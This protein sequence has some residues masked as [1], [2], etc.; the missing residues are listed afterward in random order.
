MKPRRI[1]SVVLSGMLIAMQLLMPISQAY[2]AGTS[3]VSPAPVDPQVLGP[4][5]AENADGTPAP[6]PGRRVQIEQPAYIP[7]A[8]TSLSAP[9]A[10]AETP[11]GVGNNN[12]GQQQR[13]TDNP[14]NHPG[15]HFAG[16][17]NLLN[18]NFFL[19]VG[20]F[21]IPGRGL[22]LQLARSYNSLAAANGE[23]GAF[24]YGWTHS[25]ETHI[26]DA[27]GGL[28]L[29]VVEA[30]GARH[31]YGNRHPCDPSDPLGDICYDSPPG[32][33][34]ELRDMVGGNYLLTHKNGTL[35]VFNDAGQL[36][37]IIDRYGNEINL[38]YYPDTHC[39]PDF[40]GP[41][42]TLCRV[43]DPS[44]RRSLLFHAPG[45][46]IELVQEWFHPG[47][48]G[49]AINYLYVDD[50]LVDVAY[51]EEP[52]SAPHN[53][54][55][56]EFNRMIAYN[57]PRQ[58][59]G[60]RQ[61]QA[62]VYDVQHRVERVTYFVD[63]FFDVFFEVDYAPPPRGDNG[64]LSEP[65]QA[66]V[67]AVE[68]VDGAGQLSR[69]EYGANS[70]I[71]YEGDYFYEY[72]HGWWWGKWWWWHPYPRWYLLAS[73]VDANLHETSYDYDPWGNTALIVNAAGAEQQFLWEP[74]A[75]EAP[76]AYGNI[77]AATNSLGV[78]TL[79]EYDYAG[80]VMTETQAYD[81]PEETSTVY[82]TDDYGQLVLQRD[83]L[84]R[85]TEYGYDEVGDMTV[86]TN[87]A[88][89]PTYNVYD[90]VGR[91]IVTIDQIGSPTIYEYDES[92]R[93]LA[94]IDP[95]GGTTRYTYSEDGR[96]NLVELVN[97]NGV[98]TTYAYD[99]LDRLT[100]QTNS[101]GQTTS[102]E[103]DNANRLIQRTDADGRFTE[104]AYDAKSRMRWMA[105]YEA[106][107][108]E[109]YQVNTYLYDAA[110][111]LIA[112][113][114]EH[115]RL[116]YAYDTIDQRTQ[117]EMWTPAWGMT[118]TLALEREALAGN[119]TRVEGPGGYLAEYAYD[120]YNRVQVVTDPTGL[121]T[122][123]QY[124]PGGRVANITY[125]GEVVANHNYDNLNNLRDV[126]YLFSAGDLIDYHYD[127]DTHGNMVTEIDDGEAYKYVYDPLGR[128][129]TATSELEGEAGYTYDP[130][131]NRLSASTE[132]STTTFIYDA[133]SRLLQAGDA[134]LAYNEMGARTGIT[135]NTS[136]PLT[137]LMGQQGSIPVMQTSA[138]DAAQQIPG[139]A[140]YVYD[141]DMRL[142]RVI[143]GGYV[144]Q[145][146]YDPLGSLIGYVD[147][148][149]FYTYYLRNG[150][151]VYMELDVAG[152]PVAYYILGAQDVLG[153][154]R[155]GM[156]YRFLYDGRGRVRLVLD[157]GS[158]IV[159]HYG[160]NLLEAGWGLLDFTFYNPIRMRGA[161]W[162]PGVNLVLFGGGVFWDP[163]F[164]VFLIKAWPWLY[165]PFGP[166]HP[167]RP[168]FRFWPWPWPWPRPWGWPWPQPWPFLWPWPGAWVRP[169][170]I[171]PIWPWGLRFWW[172]WWYWRWWWGWHWWGRWWCWHPWWWLNKWWWWPWWHPWWWWGYWWWPWWWWSSCWWWPWHWWWW[173]WWWPGWW[174]WAPGRFW[175]CWWWW[176]PW[177]WW[178][179][180]W[181]WPPI[182]GP[183]PDYGDAPDPPYASYARSNGAA[184]GIWWYEWLGA[185]RDGEWDSR[186]VDNDLYDDGVI[187]DPIAGTLTFMPT[188][189]L[190]NPARYH[191]AAPLHVHGW[192]DWNRDGVW[193]MADEFI[194]NWSGY[195]GD[196]IWPAGQNSFSVVQPFSVPDSVFGADDVVDLWLRFR[197]DYATN[198]EN[199][200]GY[201][202]FGEVE[203][204]RLTVVRPTR[205]PWDG[206]TIPID[207]APVI[208]FTRVVTGIAVSI[209]PAV[210]ITPVWTTRGSFNVVQAVADTYGD[211]LTI[212]HAPFTP[213][214]VYTVSLSSG[215]THPDGDPVLP[216]SFSFTA[217]CTNVTGV[218]LTLL[219]GGTLYTDT[220]VTF[221]ADIAPDDATKPYTY[222]I[223]Y[224]DG[225]PVME[226]TSSLDP[227]TLTHT[228]ATTGTYEVTFSAW[229]CEMTE[230]VTS[231]VTVIVSDHAVC[232]DV[233]GVDLSVL[234]GSPI[235]TDTDVILMADLAPDNAT[236]PYTYTF[237][238]GSGPRAAQTAS[239]EPFTIAHTFAT[240]GVHTVTVAVWNC[241]MLAADA[242]T[243]VITVTVHPK[244]V[245]PVRLTGVTLALLTGGTLYTDTQV[246]FAADFAPDNATLPIS[247][248]IAVDGVPG[249]VLTTTV[250]PLVFTDTF[251][252]P[253][254]YTVTVAAWNADMAPA[255]AV[256]DMITVTI[257]PH[258]VCV[259]VTGVTL[260]R[261][262]T[263]DIYTD[264]VV[265]FSADILLL[266]AT[267][268]Y[269][270][271]IDGGLPLTVSQN[272]VTFTRTYATTGTKT[273][274]FAAWN[275]SMTLPVTDTV[276][277]DVVPWPVEDFYIFLPLVLRDYGGP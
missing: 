179:W 88:G 24:G 175:W 11:F 190:A 27:T 263:G 185:W 54:I 154:W 221:E 222:T 111:N 114:N 49:R 26:I 183:P 68:I 186:Q 1:L 244:P 177:P 29:T 134:T 44:A 215:Y 99:A 32:L 133:H 75:Y 125:P 39:Y 258:G 19:T 71:T 127:Y 90:D 40:I 227:L 249:T 82:Q 69:V 58:P 50:N 136:L 8:V 45:G 97:A 72:D 137:Q 238:F 143:Q 116:A 165:W 275:C 274:T 261:L 43:D 138:P 5:A 253:G 104:Y 139:T 115:V 47:V 107:A 237:D 122:S 200:L 273:V 62:I 189:S 181:R 195:P 198:W 121:M 213:N 120:V 156:Y 158:A 211:Q 203:D 119:V 206:S 17:V 128:V 66:P 89:I 262:T 250:D 191:A 254:M 160:R 100:T 256:S 269:T 16:P 36:I 142:I 48:L 264:T 146:F 214:T 174:F 201:T 95:L 35:Q 240:P 18:G 131:G 76:G 192:I 2:G 74:P 207:V 108:T 41:P 63:S 84:G 3:T 151:D 80:Y 228:F 117:V 220:V 61:A 103:Y 239:T 141:N 271:T 130:V 157:P 118:Q 197:L 20:D 113:E 85:T 236:S 98:A 92:D 229:N 205:P 126:S 182:L 270:Y 277:F 259:P 77:L 59:A 164:G 78:T 144:Y 184:H 14:E 53:Y 25:Y 257:T 187:V 166:F 132:E 276:P 64:F 65:G 176:R 56:D 199:P 168:I 57:D 242:V 153:M 34:R 9:L 188:V 145:Y 219:T 149:G 67:G 106:D 46:L 267:Y 42:E 102:Y 196:G 129:I 31:D 266:N 245:P 204:H 265:H 251:A 172:P 193:N 178:S 10:P 218:N 171:W 33:Y 252:M 169:W 51:P 194:V 15:H 223:D 212:E 4:P 87:A 12:Y 110:G 247:Y 162:F 209:Q 123:Y 180:P 230:P 30:D 37:E 105:Y 224:G 170:L 235:Y 202:R 109:P 7:P 225:T 161:W 28:T 226:S 248:T 148:D 81:M 234:T 231:S 86:I 243:D 216:S 233:T 13:D 101:L 232:V 83:A 55:Y 167:W 96:D 140:S 6:S 93:L 173:I 268:P 135:Q 91:P 52:L 22:S 150:D 155:Y 70:N 217:T 60:V 112:M 23:M 159:Y 152:V 255:E 73:K 21:F 272:T 210:P 124:D 246:T 260:T 94:V 79:Y 241:A 208:T 147:A 38:Y 163:W